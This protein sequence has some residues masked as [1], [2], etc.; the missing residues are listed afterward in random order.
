MVVDVAAQ[1][2]PKSIFSH[3]GLKARIIPAAAL[4]GIFLTSHY[5]CSH[6]LT[7]DLHGP[8]LVN[9]K[10]LVPQPRSQILSREEMP[11]FFEGGGMESMNVRD[12][13]N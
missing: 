5:R 6:T 1:G 4:I 12:L 2:G 3:E 9:G 13:R 7:N 11:P 10:I 8:I